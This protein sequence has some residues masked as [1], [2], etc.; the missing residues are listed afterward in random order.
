MNTE[1]LP[2]AN[3]TPESEDAAAS[4]TSVGVGS[5]ALLGRIIFVWVKDSRVACYSA[6]EI[7]G[8][9]EE[10]RAKGW[11]HTATI[12]PARWIE[13]MVN[14]GN[15]PSDMLDELQFLPNS[16]NKSPD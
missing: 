14:G 16:Q 10:I 8:R 4:V 7:R 6:D 2:T 5:S 9:E 12:D 15:D 11:T 13:H 3:L 1:S